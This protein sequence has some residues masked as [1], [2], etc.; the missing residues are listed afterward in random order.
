MQKCTHLRRNA[1]GDSVP[2]VL[3]AIKLRFMTVKTIL[4]CVCVVIQVHIGQYR[5][6]FSIHFIL[7]FPS[8]VTLKP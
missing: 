6:V 5:K 3:K 1:F 2:C 4:L 8:F 7:V